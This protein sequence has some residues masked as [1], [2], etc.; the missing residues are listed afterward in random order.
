MTE[1]IF[2]YQIKRA[3]DSALDMDVTV[4]NRLLTARSIALSRARTK[5]ARILVAGER[6]SVFAVNGHL[7]DSKSPTFLSVILSAI[8]LCAGLFA[9][10][11][12]YEYQVANEI[13]EIDAQVLTGDLPLDAYLD[14]GFDTWLK[15]SSS[16]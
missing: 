9:I 12:W 4:E 16:R 2:G 10:N 11:H 3:L 13:E 15:R 5:A 1:Q 8:V 7:G 6:N 14:K